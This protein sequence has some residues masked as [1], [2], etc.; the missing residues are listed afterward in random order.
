VTARPARTTADHIL[1]TFMRLAGERGIDATTTRVLADEAG[2]NEVTIFRLFGAKASLA[3]KAVRRFQSADEISRY[4]L[5]IDTSS[6]ERAAEGILATVDFLRQRMLE[7]PEF[8][9]FGVAEYWHFPS[10]KDEIAATPRAA[11]ELI[12]RALV[13]ASPVLRDG[14]DVRAASLSL[15]GL[16]FVSVVW[17]ARGWVDL[18]DEEWR[19]SLKQAVRCLL[20]C[21]EPLA[22]L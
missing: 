14:L 16:I 6:P 20:A 2:V 21:G 1:R 10:L 17:S 15:I 22:E 11:R 19:L 8:V 5:R 4:P 12:E 3:E 18:S 9:Q 7:R 13:A